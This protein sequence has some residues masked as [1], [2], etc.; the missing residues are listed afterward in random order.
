MSASQPIRRFAVEKQALMDR[1]LE[2]NQNGLLSVEDAD[3]LRD[4]VDD[5]ERLM[6]ENAKSL[7]AAT[8]SERPQS[9]SAVPVTVWV[10]PSATTI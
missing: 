2:Q 3:V 9:S 7:Q 8:Q 1:L 6:I 4:L 10:K 5:A